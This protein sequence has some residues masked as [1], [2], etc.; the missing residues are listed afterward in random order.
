MGSRGITCSLFYTFKIFSELLWWE[1]ITILIKQYYFI[2]TK[3]EVLLAASTFTSHSFSGHP[4]ELPPPF[5]PN[6]AHIWTSNP[7]VTVRSLSLNLWAQASF[8]LP[9][10][11][12]DLLVLL[13]HPLQTHAS[14]SPE[15]ITCPF[16]FP[17]CSHC[18]PKEEH[19]PSFPL[20][21]QIYVPILFL[22]I[23]RGGRAGMRAS[24]SFPAKGI[25]NA[26]GAIVRIN[27]DYPSKGHSAQFAAGSH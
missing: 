7:L 17:L 4:T 14:A 12:Q 11:S 13:S 5:Q 16:L 26:H 8:S 10:L 3:K 25:D 21:F 20:Q 23:S 19:P 22:L 9:S 18:F 24:V 27:Y 6:L 1:C 15:F 2:I